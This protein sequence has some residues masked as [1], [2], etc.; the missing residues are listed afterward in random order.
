MTEDAK[1]RWWSWMP[2][3]PKPA[4]IFL[5]L[6][7]N[8][9][10]AGTWAYQYCCGP[11]AIDIRQGILHWTNILVNPNPMANLAAIL[12][13]S[14]L[15]IEVLYMFLTMKRNHDEKQEAIAKAR[16]EA[17]AE[18]EV[19]AKAAQAENQAWFEQYQADPANAPPPPWAR[20]GARQPE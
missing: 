10:I 20:N 5:A 8:L 1:P 4:I 3:I 16:S 12:A 2:S 19:A 11:L 14:Q 13:L 7:T 9:V 15:N 17:K 6:L 18:A